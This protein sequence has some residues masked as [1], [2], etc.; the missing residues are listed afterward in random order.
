MPV[1][2]W[3]D[4]QIP[5]QSQVQNFVDEPDLLTP[6]PTKSPHTAWLEATAIYSFY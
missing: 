5:H 1:R 3:G 2:F 6:S 4:A